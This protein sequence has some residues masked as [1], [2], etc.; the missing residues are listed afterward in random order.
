MSFLRS[1]TLR[2]KSCA[3]LEQTILNQGQRVAQVLVERLAPLAAAGAVVPDFWALQL[4]FLEVLRTLR[5]RVEDTERA[6][7]DELADDAEPRARRNRADSAL[8][9][10]IVELK[11]F[12]VSAYKPENVEALGFPRVLGRTPDELVRQV[13]HLIGRLGV[14]DVALPEP[15]I[16]EVNLALAD[17]ATSLQPLVD[18]LRTALVDVGREVKE[19]NLTQLDRNRAVKE[20]D[21]AFLGIARTL[22]TLYRLAGE[23]EL[24]DQVRPSVR[25]PGRTAQVVQQ[26][27]DGGSGPETTPSSEQSS[28]TTA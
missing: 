16:G 14:P 4:F 8:R 18:D 2:L 13:D 9:S 23:S 19:A 12:F 25:R 17:I 6:H 10:R 28:K 24:A 7:V 1:N 3:F 21:Q 5:G 26:D 15:I 20:Y 11:D 22:E 27:A